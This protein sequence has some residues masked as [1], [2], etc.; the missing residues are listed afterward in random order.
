[1]P[2]TD[3]PIVSLDQLAEARRIAEEN[4]YCDIGFNF[5]T[6]G[7]NLEELEKAYPL[8]RALKVYLNPTTGN[9]MIE[10]PEKIR[11]V[12]AS[13]PGQKPIMVH[14]E[15]RE[16]V[17]LVIRQ[18]ATYSKRLYICHVSLVE[19][20]E[21]IRYAKESGVQISAE[22]C[23]H[24][25]IFTEE[26]RS[27]LGPYGLM[28]PPLAGRA[29]QNALWKAIEDGTIDIIATDHAPHSPKEKASDNPPFGVISEPAFSVLWREFRRRG[30]PVTKLVQM[31]SDRPKALFDIESDTDSFMMV[32]LEEEYTFDNSMV[33]S[34]AGISPY[35]GMKMLGRIHKVVLHGVEVVAEDQILDTPAGRLI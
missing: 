6:R 2:N 14:A 20:L 7:D 27:S 12:F 25:L 3:P 31:M 30:F 16:K 4:A 19:Q 21:E 11:D 8:V 5:G 32:D 28:K 35:A 17:R 10:D 33:H 1:M 26:E 22:V 13:W 29:D 15:G 34:K 23:P 18:A 24:Y 9:L